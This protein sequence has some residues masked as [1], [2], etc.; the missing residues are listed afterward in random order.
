MY[1][2]QV[3]GRNAIPYNADLGGKLNIL[4]NQP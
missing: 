2:L 4:Q 3:Q 1:N